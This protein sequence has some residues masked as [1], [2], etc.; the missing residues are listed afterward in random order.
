MIKK[1]EKGFYAFEFLS[2]ST[3]CLFIATIILMI[4]LQSSYTEKYKVD[5]YYHLELII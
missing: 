3:V 4:A 1:N 5:K 2:I